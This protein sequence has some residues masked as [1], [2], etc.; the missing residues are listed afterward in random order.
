[1][2]QVVKIKNESGLKLAVQETPGGEVE[3]LI[4]G[5]TAENLVNG[6]DLKFSV[7]KEAASALAKGISKMI[8]DSLYRT[9]GGLL[10]KDETLKGK[11]Y[12][13]YGIN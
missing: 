12:G 2:E 6:K 4:E 1:M 3:L 13:E 8:I 9:I 7:S 10:K 5:A 11:R